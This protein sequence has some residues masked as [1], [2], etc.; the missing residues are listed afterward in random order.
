MRYVS[1]PTDEEVNALM[2]GATVFVQTSTHEGFCL[3]PLE[4]MASGTPVVCTDAHGNRDFCRD[5]ENC[6]M[7]AAEPAAVSAALARVLERRRAARAARRRRARDRRG[8]TAGRLGSR[9]SS[10]RCSRSP[11][12]AAGRGRVYRS[13]ATRGAIRLN[14][15]RPRKKTTTISPSGIAS[16]ARRADQGRL[17]SACAWVMKAWRNCWK[18]TASGLHM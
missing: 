16:A 10:R 5:G 13:S 14:V 12:A 1:E 7:P 4:A 3:P 17:R 6:L 11:T 8:A 18:R 2:A 9:R 15:R